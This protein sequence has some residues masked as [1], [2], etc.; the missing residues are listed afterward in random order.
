MSIQNTTGLSNLVSQY[1]DKKLL[2]NF[3]PNLVLYS[4]A[5]KRP[6]PKGSGSTINFHK[7]AK[8]SEV[9]T[10]LVEGV[11]PAEDSLTATRPTATIKQYG[12]YILISDLLELTAIDP[13]LDDAMK[14]LG[15]QAALSMDSL[16]RI[17]LDADCDNLYAGDNA[18]LTGVGTDD[19]LTAREILRGRVSMQ[20][21]DVMD[22]A[23]LVA[24]PICMF[25]LK[26]DTAAGGWMEV[27][28]YL[29]KE[30]QIMKGEEGKLF[31]VR[32][33]SSSNI[34]STSDGTESS[35]D[36]YSNLLCTKGCFGAVEL[37][38]K[39][40]KT[41]IV[42]RKASIADPLAQVNSVGWKVE[43]FAA[44]YLGTTST[45]RRALRIRAGSAFT[46]AS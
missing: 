4:L 18:A 24:H 30:S 34:N 45:E 27:S 36:V 28:K 42:P 10:P 11:A 6:I 17:E 12:N 15:K 31:N 37:D 9:T 2:M 13:I 19:P 25:D 26:A 32:I 43:G 44:A 7:I 41:M 33:V 35:A 22:E 1:Y 23:V 8:L 46:N 20:I 39:G 21:N 16:C 38:S 40:V 14:E 5:Q 29:K 3:Y